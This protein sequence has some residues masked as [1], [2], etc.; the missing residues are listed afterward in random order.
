MQPGTSSIRWSCGAA[1]SVAQFGVLYALTRTFND[2]GSLLEI[3]L[4]SSINAIIAVGMTLVAA[5]AARSSS[6]RG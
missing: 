3:M 6:R 2:P 4:Q 5:K 1:E